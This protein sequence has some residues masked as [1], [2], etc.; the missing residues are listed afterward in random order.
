VSTPA[1]GT[2]ETSGDEDWFKVNLTAAIPYNISL[3]AA[4]TD[5]GTLSD[6]YFSGVYDATGRFLTSG[7]S[8]YYYGS[9][10]SNS[11]ASFTPTT[12]GDY[13][14]SAGASTSNTGTYQLSVI[15]D[16]YAANTATTGSV[17]VSGFATGTIE[18]SGDKDWFKVNLTAGITYDINLE[19]EPTNKGTLSD[20]YFRGIYEVTAGQFLYSG[21]YPYYTDDDSGEGSNSL[22]SFTPTTTDDYYLVAGASGSNTGTYQLSV[23]AAIDDY[24]A[25]TATTGWVTVS[26][27]ATGNIETDDD[28]DWFKVNL[29]S[30]TTYNIDLEAARTNKGT[31]NKTYL[32]ILILMLVLC[33]LLWVFIIFQLGL[34]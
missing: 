29:I 20:T 25:N 24:T 33:L 19:A 1:T 30:G 23:T 10:D 11:L 8:N 5:K 13:Y 27:F 34:I 15:I 3:E 16:D 12:T 7:Y 21:N 17:A 32:C 28:R 6:P 2:I 4:P 9:G 18:T 26:S 14:L 22:V 31:L